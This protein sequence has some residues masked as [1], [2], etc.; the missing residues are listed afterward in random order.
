MKKL[1]ALFLSLCLMAGIAPVFAET[2]AE[3][4]YPVRFDLR[5]N[6]VVTPVK[7]LEYLLGVCR[8]CSRGNQHS[9]DVEGKRPAD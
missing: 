7:S 2:A 1:I 6:G 9:V 3:E 5:D 8:H 4:K